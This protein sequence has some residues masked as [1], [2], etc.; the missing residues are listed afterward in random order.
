MQTLFPS[1]SFLLLLSPFLSSVDSISAL[2]VAGE[3]RRWRRVW[4][5]RRG[6]VE[7]RETRVFISLWI[8]TESILSNCLIPSQSNW[9]ENSQTRCESTHVD[10]MLTHTHSLIHIIYILNYADMKKCLA[11][12]FHVAPFNKIYMSCAWFLSLCLEASPVGR[13]TTQ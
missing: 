7:G 13:E 3:E 5:R 11:I 6:L 12:S 9:Q 1:L 10:K 2:S 8:N 4:K